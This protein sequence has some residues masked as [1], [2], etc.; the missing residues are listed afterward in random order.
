LESR[1]PHLT[2]AKN[3]RDNV[4][5]SDGDRPATHAQSHMHIRNAGVYAA[6]TQ[7][8]TKDKTGSNTQGREGVSLG[9]P[10]FRA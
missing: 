8:A 10:W 9:A 2:H 1:D 7:D 4:K 6:Y 5:T 3:Q